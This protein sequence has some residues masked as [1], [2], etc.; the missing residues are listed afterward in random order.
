MLTRSLSQKE[1]NKYV[2]K[3]KKTEIISNT[4]FDNSIKPEMNYRKKIGEEKTLQIH[5][6][7]HVIKQPVGP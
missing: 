5:G 3:S 1:I 4:F 2:H 7:K 6:D